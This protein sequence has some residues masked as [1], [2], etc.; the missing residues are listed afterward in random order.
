M[1]K[2]NPKIVTLGGGTGAPTIIRALI[3]AGF[4]NISAISTSM[5]SG[6]K[7]G[8]IRS[9]ERDR[10][11]AASDLLRN[12]LAL[13]SP[14]DSRKKNV[15][16]LTSILNFIDGRNRNLGY[17]IY[18]ALLEKYQNDFLKVQKHLESLLNIKLKGIAIPISLFPT[19][20]CF[21]TKSGAICQGEHQLDRQSLSKDTI[22][23]IWLKPKVQATKQALKAIESA[24]HII[25]C[26]GSFYG[27][28]VT[29][30][31]PL[32]ITQSLQKTK[33]QKILITNLVSTRNETHRLTP[34][35][36]FQIF[37]RYTKLDLPFNHLIIPQSTQKQF[38]QRYPAVKSSYTSEHSHFLGWPQNQTN[39]L[40]SKGIKI[41]RTNSFYTT[42]QLN[43]LRH[44][45][46]KLKAFLK[47][48]IKD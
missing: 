47:K 12:L 45:P 46:Q 44:D 26:P 14:Q 43:R 36:Y 33:A 24:T 23:K 8:V 13:I 42:P 5:D 6:G 2:R 17:T 37:Q 39:S 20:I 32:G 9:D 48:I 16:A 38:N 40:K 11:I 29:N 25:Y 30:F 21:E 34:Q 22:K 15:T 19:N 4:S 18:Y 3:L 35:K 27:S 41:L 31:L 10:V 28:V 7:T 1:S